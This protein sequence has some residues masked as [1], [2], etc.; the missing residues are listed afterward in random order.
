MS[1]KNQTAGIN[2]PKSIKGVPKDW[3]VLKVIERAY[4]VGMISQYEAWFAFHPKDLSPSKLETGRMRITKPDKSVVEYA[5]EHTFS[6]LVFAQS[7]GG[8]TLWWFAVPCVGVPKDR[9][10]K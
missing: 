7:P 5:R 4:C 1:N 9:R 2:P 10:L 6:T 3:R 8:G